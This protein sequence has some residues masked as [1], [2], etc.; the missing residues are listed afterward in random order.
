MEK[1]KIKP[2]L[3]L[4]KRLPVIHHN[5]NIQSNFNQIFI[6]KNKNYLIKINCKNFFKI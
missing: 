2:Y 6:N 1:G 3:S 4:F 5:E